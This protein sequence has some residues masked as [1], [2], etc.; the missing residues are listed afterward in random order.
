MFNCWIREKRRKKKK[1]VRTAYKLQRSE[2][3]EEWR[4]PRI[5][6]CS[7]CLLLLSICFCYHVKRQ[8]MEL[9][10]PT[11]LRCHPG[12]SPIFVFFLFLIILFFNFSEPSRND[13]LFSVLH[14]NM[15]GFTMVTG[16]KFS[17]QLLY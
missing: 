13:V 7:S 15:S 2:Q 11:V 5:P 14:P 4:A 8:R 17:Y 1:H 12:R 6:G 9:P 16:P 3:K 10:P